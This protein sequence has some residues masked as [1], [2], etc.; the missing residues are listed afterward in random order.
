MAHPQV[1]VSKAIKSLVA[2]SMLVELYLS[3]AAQTIWQGYGMLV[4]PIKMIQT[5]RIMK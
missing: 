4:D 1:V 5:N 2:H 3:L